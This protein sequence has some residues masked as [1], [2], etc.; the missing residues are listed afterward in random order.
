MVN[1]TKPDGT[2]EHL[3]AVR[4]F[5]DY[6]DGSFGDFYQEL[7]WQEKEKKSQNL[8]GL[9]KDPAL[10]P[11]LYICSHVGCDDRILIGIRDSGHID[12][13]IKTI[14][15]LGWRHQKVDEVH[16]FTCPEHSKGSNT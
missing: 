11:A 16:T 5:H 7:P 2:V 1:K 14:L 3:E 4:V 6:G 12:Y 8:V 13:A 9:K 10:I 15:D